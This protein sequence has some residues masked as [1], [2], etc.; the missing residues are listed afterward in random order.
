MSSKKQLDK[1]TGKDHPELSCKKKSSPA[2]E[3]SM[4]EI[5]GIWEYTCITVTPKPFSYPLSV[6]LRNRVLS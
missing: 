2:Q 6:T 4:L 3:V 1:V 5:F